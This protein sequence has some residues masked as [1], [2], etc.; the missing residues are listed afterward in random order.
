[1][2]YQLTYHLVLR[3]GVLQVELP[4]QFIQEPD[5]LTKIIIVLDEPPGYPGYLSIQMMRSY[6]PWWKNIGPHCF[7]ISPM[8][9]VIKGGNLIMYYPEGRFPFC[10]CGINLLGRTRIYL[11]EPPRLI[12]NFIQ[13]DGLAGFS[14]SSLPQL[15]AEE[16]SLEMSN[17]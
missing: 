8:A 14:L 4:S 12:R 13:H 11:F 9:T 5:Y 7:K 3:K 2:Y 17:H 16:A 15:I 10:F 1:M 6:P